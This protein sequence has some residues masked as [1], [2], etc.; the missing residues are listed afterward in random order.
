MLGASGP[1][2]M[3]WG[4]RK[5]TCPCGCHLSPLGPRLRVSPRNMDLRVAVGQMPSVAAWCFA[6]GVW[7]VQEIPSAAPCSPLSTLFGPAD[8][9]G[10]SDLCN[11]KQDWSEAP[12]GE[13][14]CSRP[15]SQDMQSWEWSRVLCGLGPAP[16]Q[17][18]PAPP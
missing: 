16:E 11:N 15:H 4:C 10:A 12:R 5:V 6:R 3:E 8:A 1:L 17:P 9:V 14:T 7:G 2:S 13:V 18:A